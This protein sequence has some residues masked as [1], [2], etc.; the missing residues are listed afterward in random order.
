M[1]YSASVSIHSPVA[2]NAELERRI[3]AYLAS[4]NFLS[5]R[6]LVVR[7]SQ[8]VVSLNGR[9]GSYYERQVAIESARRVAG[10]TRIV[11]RM[12]VDVVN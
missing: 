1:S 11:D 9:L 5:F 10:A 2:A 12:V 7:A 8:G 6:R 3:V 4:R